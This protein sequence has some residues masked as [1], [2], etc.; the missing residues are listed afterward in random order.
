M[1]V[2]IEYEITFR[3]RLD[4]AIGRA[5][6]ITERLVVHH[7][8]EEDKYRWTDPANIKAREPF[9][10]AIFSVRKRGGKDERKYELC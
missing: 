8:V 10:R 7:N 4:G 3:G 6:P 1:S 5:Y 9:L 2:P